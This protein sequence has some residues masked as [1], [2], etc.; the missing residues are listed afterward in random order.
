MVVNKHTTCLLARHRA[1]LGISMLWFSCLVVQLS[2][3]LT[4]NSIKLHRRAIRK[5]VTNNKRR[6]SLILALHAAGDGSGYG[7]LGKVYAA[8]KNM[9]DGLATG[10]GWNN[11][12]GEAWQDPHVC[13]PLA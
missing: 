1:I 10:T 3:M 8:V 6:H 2:W 7:D 11:E 13:A 9:H 4:T 5:L 12:A